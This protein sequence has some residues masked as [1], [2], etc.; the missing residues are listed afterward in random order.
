M[1]KLIIIAMLAIIG[2][3][4]HAQTAY[5]LNAGDNSVT[6]I[7]VATNTIVT[8]ITGFSNPQAVS[9]SP[10]GSKVYVAD[11][12]T[13]S[14]SVIS[15]SANTVIAKFPAGIYPNGVAV[16]PDGNTVY[17]TNAGDSSVS[18][19]NSAADTVL[20]TI[21]VGNSPRGISASPDGSKIYVANF[22]SN[23][24]SVINAV[25]DSIS[26][27][28]P[29]GNYPCGVSVSPD[30]SKVYVTNQGSQ[31][32]S[33]INTAADTVS[34]TITV[35]NSPWGVSVSPDGSKVYVAN[36]TSSTVSVINSVNNTV[37]ATILL[38]TDSYP[39][40]V[41]VSPDGS[42]VYIAN[43][44]TGGTVSVINGVTNAITTTIPV[45]MEPVTFGNF[46]STY[47]QPT[48]PVNISASAN[49][50]CS[51]TSITL[52]VG[53]ANTYLWSD[54]LGTSDTLLV[55]PTVTTTYTVTGTTEGETGTASITINV[56]TPVVPNI[57]MVTTD[58][59]S[60]YNYNVVYWDK[61]PY[62]NVDSFIVYR[63]DVVSSTY[64][65][66][67]AVSANALSEFTDTSFSIGGPNGGNPRYSS[68]F[69]K[70]AIRDTC[71]NIGNM[72]PYH[73]SMFVQQSGSN[74]SW[75]AYGVESGQT[76]PVTGYS[77]LRDDNNTGNWHVLVNTGGLSTT[78]PDYATYPNGN[79]RIDALGF[80]CA[81]TMRLSGMGSF[82]KS[83]SN[84]IKPVPM[85]IEQHSL[86]NEQIMIYP[87]PANE[88]IKVISEQP[89][90]N[91]VEIYNLLG[92]KI[93]STLITENRSAITINIATFSKGVYFVKVNTAKGMDVKKIV[94]E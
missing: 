12:H 40:G 83:H 91:S 49:L 70:L 30:G 14:V 69:Y 45:G 74:F 59:S 28:I 63:K 94:K 4:L 6:V 89:T 5:I 42:K 54:S 65:R 50:I 1:K 33:V 34:A 85:G 13:D 68:W 66:I 60:F 25:A 82:I 53:G 51:G 19:I 71:G 10:D 26:A 2:L 87:N 18:V 29:V 52:T 11:Y 21:F 35:G 48:L 8:T 27:T 31:S 23:T 92:E 57:C 81:P 20:A 73:Q 7:N 55:S 17:V 32:V 44:S 77:F 58:S 93:Y 43:G 62:T 46:I 88:E 61:T 64:L 9:V 15:T 38:P 75:N 80:D 39:L 37:T 79:W 86:N 78:D 41:S 76:N 24:V 22:N 90:V 16:S 72:S 67:G 47:T 3:S 56:V 36:F 84:T